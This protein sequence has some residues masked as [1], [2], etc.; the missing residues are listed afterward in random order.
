VVVS[1]GDVIRA[2]VLHYL[3][4]PI[5]AYHT[6]EIDPGSITTLALDETGGKIIGLNE[7][8]AP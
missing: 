1:H 8:V 4:R 7:A 3:K 5:D 2:A 6:F